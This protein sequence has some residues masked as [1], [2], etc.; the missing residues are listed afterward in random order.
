[1][2]GEQAIL[3][4]AYEESRTSSFPETPA[5]GELIWGL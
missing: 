4:F 5:L 2:Q 3:L 1:M